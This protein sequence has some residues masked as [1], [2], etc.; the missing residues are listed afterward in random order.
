LINQLNE[1]YEFLKR[2]RIGLPSGVLTLD[3]ANPTKVEAFYSGISLELAI[4]SLEASVNLYTG[5]N[6][7]GLDDLLIAAEAMKGTETLDA[8]IQAQFSKAKDA[9][10]ALQGPLSAAVENDQLAVQQAYAELS[11]QLVHIKTDMP[12]VLCVAITYIDNPSD[13]D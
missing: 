3:I 8:V 5:S 1:N 4:K 11:Q 13:S 6:G 7:L 12:T 10:E 9:L 2:D